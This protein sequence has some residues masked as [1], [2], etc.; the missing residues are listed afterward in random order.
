MKKT[1]TFGILLLLLLTSCAAPT[2]EPRPAEAEAAPNGTQEEASTAP[3]ELDGH[4]PAEEPQTVGD[5]VSGYC[6]NTVT[7]VTLDGE[8]YSFWGDDSVALTDIV[9]NLAYDPDRIC[10]CPPEFTVDTEFGDGY[11]VNLTSHYVRC[12]EGQAPLTAEQAETIQGILDRN[13]PGDG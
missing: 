5:P 10:R 13:C 8:T 7:E 2:E 1:L 11:G 4:T 6:G 9:I 3:E 12:E